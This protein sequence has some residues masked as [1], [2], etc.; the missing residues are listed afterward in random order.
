MRKIQLAVPAGIQAVNIQLGVLAHPDLPVISPDEL[1]QILAERNAEFDRV[2]AE[3]GDFTGAVRPGTWDDGTPML[4]GES[5]YTVGLIAAIESL[6]FH[7]TD[8]YTTEVKKGE[9]LKP[10]T[11][12]VFTK[13]MAPTARVTDAVRMLIQSMLERN[14]YQ[15]YV[16][17]NPL[18]SIPNITINAWGNLNRGMGA[19][20]VLTNVL[21]E[22]PQA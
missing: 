5:L 6:G 4:K 17:Y 22:A 9:T 1:R 18:H 12:A 10:Q 16:W 2:K 20:L 11:V 19:E 15:A 13:H 21:A 7:L 8:V 14:F 3:H